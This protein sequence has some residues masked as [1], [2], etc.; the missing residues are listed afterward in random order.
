MMMPDWIGVW[1]DNFLGI[2]GQLRGERAAGMAPRRGMSS[3]SDSAVDA[4]ARREA[5][6]RV[7]EA[8]NRWNAEQDEKAKRG[9]A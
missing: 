4:Y 1:E 6:R 9:R 3:Y 8:I 5:T 7:E 2:R